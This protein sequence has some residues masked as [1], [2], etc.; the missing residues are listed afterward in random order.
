MTT[1]LALGFGL[2]L[3]QDGGRPIT[4]EE[5]L[6]TAIENNPTLAT[7]RLARLQAD[8]TV[9]G[10]QGQ[11]DP[12]YT[13][14]GSY[15]RS[16]SQGFFQG[17]PF[18]STSET[19]NINN[20]LSGTLGTGT[21]YALNAGL[22]RN[23][24]T[25]ITEFVP[26][27][28]T[29]QEQDVFT[30]NMNISVTQQLLEGVLYRY[31]VQNV[32]RARQQLTT[33]EL[34]EAK[35]TQDA[36]YNAAEAYWSWVY[37]TELQ[38]IAGESVAVA[39]EALRVGR[40]QVDNGTLAPVE[41]TRL[42]AALV[43]SQQASLDAENTAEQAANALLLA[44]GQSPD[45]AIVPATPA[46]DV[47]PDEIDVGSAIEVAMAQNVDLM[48][49]RANLE[50]ANLDL[51]NAKHAM[52]PSLSATGSAGVAAQDN[53]IG[54]AISGLTDEDNQ[55]FMSIA[56]RFTVPLG[57]R[58]ARGSRDTNIALVGQRERELADLERSVRAQV[59]QQ[60]LT[61]QSARRR[62]ELSDANLR[63][64]QQTLEA[65]E[66]LA[67]AGRNIQRDVLQARTEVDRAKA[68]AAKARTDYRLAQAQLLRLQGQLDRMAP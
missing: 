12:S 48:V 55:P 17:F 34:G 28:G 24:S 31:N 27:Q 66:A 47:P 32:T 9:K 51:T 15:R 4:Y 42:E 44:L 7:A 38:R 52:L 19:W 26:G 39:E 36:L 10:A 63:L 41:G 60:V 22:D 46:G 64:A 6:S 37:A 35:A 68:D 40:L 1:W 45:Q 59:E 43:Q 23:F 30:S 29:E 25:F 65:E 54:S 58:A 21:T 13:L 11:F 56:G 50:L 61:L 57:N 62:M 5:A 49:S 20:Q 2:A 16:T 14:D 67:S 3:A 8:G 53:A 18:S 33:A